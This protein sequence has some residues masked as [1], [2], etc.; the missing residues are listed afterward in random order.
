MRAKPEQ[1]L[2]HFENLLHSGVEGRLRVSKACEVANGR[3][4][5]HCYPLCMLSHRECCAELPLTHAMAVRLFRHHVSNHEGQ[6]PLVL[7]MGCLAL[8]T[9]P[10]RNAWAKGLLAYQVLGGSQAPP[11]FPGQ[12]PWS[13][14]CGQ[15][16]LPPGRPSRAE[17][18]SANLPWPGACPHV[19]PS[20]A[21]MHDSSEHLPAM[22]NKFWA[23]QS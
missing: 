6:R 8:D 20:S 15:Q 21:C 7:Q 10:S 18:A 19:P 3:P 23:A 1:Q 22:M 12:Y 2:V 11:A 16:C 9:R 4:Q 14:C 5:Q 13:V 17:R